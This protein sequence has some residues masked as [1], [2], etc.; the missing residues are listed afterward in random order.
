LVVLVSLR[1]RPLFV[2][3]AR[4]LV[5]LDMAGSSIPCGAGGAPR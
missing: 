4:R 2:S 5:G 3:A 1:L